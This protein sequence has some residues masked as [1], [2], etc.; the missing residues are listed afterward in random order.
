MK[1]KPT[2][3]NNLKV[4][5][6]GNVIGE[7]TGSIDLG[8]YELEKETFKETEFFGTPI[9]TE[10]DIVILWQKSE[11]DLYWVMNGSAIGYET[12]EEAEKAIKNILE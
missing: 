5:I 7:L 12:K 4:T 10:S 1:N 3:G 6:D 2:K 8:N 11:G 9:K